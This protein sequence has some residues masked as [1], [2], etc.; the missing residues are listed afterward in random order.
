[1][2]K[3]IAILLLSIISSISV[4]QIKI[5]TLNEL[6]NNSD[7]GWPFVQQMI[8]SAKNKIEVLP[9][10][11]TR[12]KQALYQAQVTTRSPMGAIIYTTGGILVDGGWIRILGSGSKKLNR[13]LPDWNKGK[14]YKNSGEVPGY[15]LIADDAIGGFFAINNGFFG[16]TLGK[17]FYLSADRL[18]W[19]QLNMNYTDFLYFCFSDNLNNFYEN[20]RWLNWRKDVDKL[21]GDK[22]FNFYPYL[23]SKEGKNINQNKRKIIPIEEQFQFNMKSRQHLGL[24]KAENN[25]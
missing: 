22:V 16:K 17:V 5:R 3:C 10:D 20:L 15:Y 19:E 1:M 13:S 8:D 25:L 4:A 21:K 9:C 11:T 14:S 23:W 2:I 7:P 24:N 12:A 18:V 6:I